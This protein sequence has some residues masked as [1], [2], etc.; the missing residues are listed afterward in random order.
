MKKNKNKGKKKLFVVFG[1]LIFLF[2][3]DFF[4]QKI[5]VEYFIEL[6]RK[7]LNKEKMVPTETKARIKKKIFLLFGSFFKNSVCFIKRNLLLFFF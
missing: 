7:V 6:W 4:S 3:K 5:A 2:C 1:S